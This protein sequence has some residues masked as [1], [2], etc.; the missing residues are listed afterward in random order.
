MPETHTRRAFLLALGASAAAALAP[1][2]AFAAFDLEPLYPPTDLSY[3]DAPIAPR[4]AEILFGCAAITWGGDDERAI[5]EVAEVGYRGIQLRASAVATFGARPGALRDL[6]AARRLELVALS[7]GNVSADPATESAEV[8]SH[9]RN[10]AFLRDAGG[11]YLQLIDAARPSGRKAD[12]DD[13]LR[14]G[15]RMTEIGKRAADLGVKVGYHH[16]MGSLGQAPD[17]VARVMD[18]VDRRYVKLV[19]DTAH[20]AQGG[21][22][23][24]RAVRQYR[25]DILFLH[26]KDLESPVPG[27][28]TKAYR[29][30]ELGRG[31]VDFPAVF[32]AL[33]ETKFRG[34]AVV[35]LDAVPDPTRTPK[36]SAAISKRYLEEKLGMRV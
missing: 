30:V 14:L 33:D 1:K 26:V 18:A 9:A 22:D 35:E 10:A 17:E 16:H 15:R 13:F 21:G 19:L 3:F 8:A 4:A 29:F 34:W 11:R 25:G 5:R 6:L 24:A 12:A 36:E 32:A 28:A 31:R 27:D 20:Y 7:S 23:P 2:D